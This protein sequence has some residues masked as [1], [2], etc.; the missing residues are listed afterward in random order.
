VQRALHGSG[1]PDHTR[2]IALIFG[3]DL[4]LSLSPVPRAA[5]TASE[6]W[7]GEQ[8]VSLLLT[9]CE[10]ESVNLHSYF[11]RIR[12]AVSVHVLERNV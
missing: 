4:R 5:G 2:L 10:K 11:S 7:T 8:R 6:R 12:A 9:A 3:T 1:Y